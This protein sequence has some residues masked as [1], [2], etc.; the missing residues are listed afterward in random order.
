M[1]RSVF[2]I[3]ST[4]LGAFAPLAGATGLLDQAQG[5]A[6]LRMIREGDTV[7]L[8]CAPCSDVTYGVV[9]VRERALEP[10]GERYRLLLNGDAVD[11]T[12]VFVDDGYGNGWQNLALLLGFVDETLP[13]GLKTSLAEVSRLAPHTGRYA[14]TLG[15][16]PIE[17]ELLLRGRGLIGSYS[18]GDGAT[19]QLLAAAFT[20]TRKAETL[21]LIERDAGDRV[22]ATLHGELDAAAGT[23]EGTRTP[24]EGTPVQPFLVRRSDSE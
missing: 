3:V 16:T 12:T 24:L 23:F 6:A 5:D 20:A 2:A 18:S 13:R 21:A 11:V 4:L 10:L 1:R 14:G 8:F 7:R 9:E 15:E 22:T 17:M 19:H